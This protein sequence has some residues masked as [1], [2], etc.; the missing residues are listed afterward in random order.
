MHYVRGELPTACQFA[1]QLLRR[2]QDARDQT[3]LLF[4]NVA[5]GDTS[6]LLRQDRS[7]AA[8]VKI[9]FQRAIEVA[10]KQNAKSFELRAAVSLARL[11]ESQNQRGEARA[12]LAGVHGWFTEGFDTADLK[13]AKALLEGL[14][15]A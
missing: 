10:R 7:N 6:L 12:M 1:E 8:Q 13:D 9:C 14:A 2:A 4:A 11:L 15:S 3:L 5:L